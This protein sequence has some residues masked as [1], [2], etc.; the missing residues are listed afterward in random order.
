MNNK[1][2]IIKMIFKLKE[3]QNERE[4]GLKNESTNLY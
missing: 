2:E 1:K 4:K 3:K